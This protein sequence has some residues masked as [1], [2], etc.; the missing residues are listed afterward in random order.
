MSI[1][2]PPPKPSTG[3]I[4]NGEVVT[5]SL[6]SK[7]G[8]GIG[9]FAGELPCRRSGE[10]AYAVRVL[11]KMPDVSDQYDLNLIQWA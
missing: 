9:H 10:H 1:A 8:D 6:E 11:P 2:T 7:N 3:A 4:E 5:M